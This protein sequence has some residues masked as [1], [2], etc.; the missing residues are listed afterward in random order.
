MASSFLRKMSSQVKKH[1]KRYLLTK[2]LVRGVFAECETGQAVA[3][4]FKGSGEAMPELSERFF[5]KQHNREI[6]CKKYLQ[7]LH[8]EIPFALLDEL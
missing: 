2:H 6:N 7:F 3:Q 4:F 5:S 8:D 1:N